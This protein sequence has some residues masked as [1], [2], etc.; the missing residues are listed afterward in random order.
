MGL[1]DRLTRGWRN[2]ERRSLSGAPRM[3][4]LWTMAADHPES[5]LDYPHP[6][7]LVDCI[8]EAVR[9]D[10]IVAYLRGGHT[11]VRFMGSS[12]CRF[13]NC[14]HDQRDTLGSTDLTDGQWIWPKGLS[15][16]MA[17]HGIRLPDA[18]VNDA[19]SHQ[20]V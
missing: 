13:D 9:R 16:Y 11:R 6:T 19:A 5:H 15:H 8:W 1:F 4:G 12:F 20:F 14:N 17:D 18:F 2:V 10:R 3:I 7:S